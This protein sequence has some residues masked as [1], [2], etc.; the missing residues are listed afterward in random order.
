MEEICNF[1]RSVGKDPNRYAE[2]SWKDSLTLSKEKARQLTDLETYFRS[3]NGEL[4]S[5]S[6]QTH[7]TTG[8]MSDIPKTKPCAFLMIKPKC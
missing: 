3:V 1:C 4:S 6:T 5:P 2:K 8:T 7:G